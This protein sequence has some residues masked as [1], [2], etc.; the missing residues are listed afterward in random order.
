M[1]IKWYNMPAE[2]E[3]KIQI[4]NYFFASV[5]AIEAVIKIYAH[6]KNYFK[7]AWNIFDFCIV[8]TSWT[9]TILI[10]SNIPYDLKILQTISRTM[11]I[12]RLFRL[13]NYSPPLQIILLTLIEASPAILTL[14]LLLGLLIFM[15]SIIGIS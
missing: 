10:M 4:A 2:I 13:A 11:R 5:F 3:D 14:G 9:F 7:D 12:L 15:Y 1:T 6:R 8:I